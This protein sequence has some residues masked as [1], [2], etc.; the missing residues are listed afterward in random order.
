MIKKLYYSDP[1]KTFD[2]D[3]SVDA[4]HISSIEMHATQIG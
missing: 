1:S 2:Q 4:C 3:P